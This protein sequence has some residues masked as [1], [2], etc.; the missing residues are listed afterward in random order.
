MSNNKHIKRYSASLGNAN[1]AAMRFHS[2]PT[3]MVTVIKKESKCGEIGTFIH[4]WVGTL[5][6]AA[7]L[8]KIWWFFKKLEL[9][10]GP[11]FPLS[12]NPRE[13]KVLYPARY[14]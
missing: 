14:V 2:I 1:Q 6:G 4:C 12:I 7:A 10:N 5:N 3:I 11:T 13:M 9:L 8:E